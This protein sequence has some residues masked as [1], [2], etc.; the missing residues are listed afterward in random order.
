MRT[1]AGT[2]DWAAREVGVGAGDRLWS[3]GSTSTGRHWT[4]TGRIGLGRRWCW[5]RAG[6]RL[7]GRACSVNRRAEISVWCSVLTMLVL[8]GGRQEAP[9][10]TLRAVIFA[11]EVFPSKYLC[12]LMQLVPQAR[13]LN[14][15]RPT[16]TN[17]CT[18]YEVPREGS[19]PIG[20]TLPGTQAIVRDEDGGVVAQGST[21]ERVIHGPTVMHGYWGDPERTAA[22]LSTV[23]SE[24]RYRTGDLVRVRANGDLE[25]TGRRD[26]HV[27]TRGYRV[28]LGEIEAARQALEVVVQAAM[29]AVPDDTITN[30]LAAF[31]VTSEPIAE[32]ELR[33]PYGERLRAYS[34]PETFEF[35]DELP[36]P[37]TGK[38]DRMSLR[39]SNAVGES[40]VPAA[41]QTGAPL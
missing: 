23:G 41:Q 7:S 5:S 3:H 15:Y 33:R 20:R 19:L 30:R 39:G 26:S 14:F 35:G 6:V 12:Q 16:E 21:G 4:Y 24:Q 13:Y 9:V 18:Q 31:V 40:S 37:S 36:K 32:R 38:V 28:E 17:V 29:I 27:K 1:A 8:R 34:I 25:Y 2:V 11:G 22:T 10:T